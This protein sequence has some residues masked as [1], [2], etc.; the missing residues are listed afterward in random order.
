MLLGLTIPNDLDSDSASAKVQAFQE[1]LRAINNESD[2]FRACVDMR[3]KLLEQQT[4]MEWLFACME[5]VMLMECAQYKAAKERNVLASH[6]YSS[7]PSS[8]RVLLFC[9]SLPRPCSSAPVLS[10]SPYLRQLFADKERDSSNQLVQANNFILQEPPTRS[11]GWNHDF[12]VPGANLKKGCLAPLIKVSGYWDGEKVRHYGWASMGWKFCKVLGT[13]A[14]RNPNWEEASVKLNQLLLRRI[15]NGRSLRVSVNHI[16]LIDLEHLKL[17]LEQDAFTKRGSKGFT[18]PY[19]RVSDTDLP[20]GYVFD[21]YG[22][23]VSKEAVSQ[24]QPVGRTGETCST[25]QPGSLQSSARDDMT[26]ISAT[27]APEDALGDDLISPSPPIS[28]DDRALD[29]ST[30][31]TPLLSPGAAPPQILADAPEPHDF[32][33]LLLSSPTISPETTVLS[34][35]DTP[36]VRLQ[37][38]SRLCLEHG[39]PYVVPVPRMGRVRQSTQRGHSRPPKRRHD[40]NPENSHICA[41]SDTMSPRFLSAIERMQQTHII[42]DVEIAV[43]YGEQQDALCPKHL[44]I[45]A[46]WAT[47]GMLRSQQFKDGVLF[48]TLKRPTSDLE[49]TLPLHLACHPRYCTFRRL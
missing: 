44:R 7:R 12:G 15:A 3:D 23:I 36:R 1:T 9:P 6:T 40:S 33:A 49:D 18:L 30:S 32:T 5:E 46:A 20:A 29:G 48:S 45:Y 8:V 21:R 26:S 16:E 41:C 42:E 10:S 35:S 37:T 13:A 47:T 17:W 4:E 38:S 34:E 22:L 25:N 27:I 43:K 39:Q 11:C 31:S 2:K 28:S 14:S 19:K 24:P